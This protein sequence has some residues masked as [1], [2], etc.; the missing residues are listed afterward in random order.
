[1]IT[2]EMTTFKEWLERENQNINPEGFEYAEKQLF[3]LTENQLIGYTQYIN[4]FKA[5]FAPKASE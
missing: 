2:Y 4:Q 3:E 5:M 1:M